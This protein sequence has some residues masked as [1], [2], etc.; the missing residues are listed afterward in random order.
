[1]QTTSIWPTR[2]GGCVP[3]PNIAFW[4]R[5]N[6]ALQWACANG[7]ELRIFLAIAN[8]PPTEDHSQMADAK[9]LRGQDLLKQIIEPSSKIHE[10]YQ[11]YKFLLDGGQ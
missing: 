4:L 7:V 10:K 3:C 2:S 6:Q 11:T 1:M 9:Q 8:G 5:S